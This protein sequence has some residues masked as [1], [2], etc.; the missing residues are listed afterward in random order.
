MQD[1]SRIA[2]AKV[3]IQPKAV[4]PWHTHPGPVLINVVKGNFIY[5]LADDCL[6]LWYMPGQAAPNR[7]ITAALYSPH[8]NS[9]CRVNALRWPPASS[10]PSL[11][12]APSAR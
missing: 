8:R 1:A 7:E 3:T 9:R 2:I 6:E 5:V 10:S 11:R 4:F 12:R